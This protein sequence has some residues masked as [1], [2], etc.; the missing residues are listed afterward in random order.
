MTT[1][2]EVTYPQ[3]STDLVGGLVKRRDKGSL[4]PSQITMALLDYKVDSPP[5]GTTW[6]TPTFTEQV[7]TYTVRAKV[8]HGPSTS[9]PL[10]PGRYRAWFRIDAN[11]ENSF[12]PCDDTFR[13][14]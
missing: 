13:I 12:Y 6:V 14:V 10:V 1:C 7:N 9:F 8:L 4:T 11:P 5:V 3:Y 2:E